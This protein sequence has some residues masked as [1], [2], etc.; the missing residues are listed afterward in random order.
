MDSNNKAQDIRTLIFKEKKDYSKAMEAFYDE[1]RKRT[2]VSPNRNKK[3]EDADY[4]TLVHGEKED[5]KKKGFYDLI[6]MVPA[7]YLYR[8]EKSGITYK[9][10]SNQEAL[11]TL[12]PD[13]LNFLSSKKG[14]LEQLCREG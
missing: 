6:L 4:I 3:V 5:L 11:Q 10:L 13:S 14:G 12:T 7:S 2:D 8:I 1:F 9:E